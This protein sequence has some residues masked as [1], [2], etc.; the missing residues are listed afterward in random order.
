MFEKAQASGLRKHA[1][2]APASQKLLGFRLLRDLTLIICSIGVRLCPDDEKRTA[3]C[4]WASFHDK[5]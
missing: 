1:A 5:A 2:F 4:E 3:L